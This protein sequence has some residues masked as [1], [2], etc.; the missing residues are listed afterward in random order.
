MSSAGGGSIAYVDAGGA[1]RVGPESAGASPGPAC[2]GVGTR[3]TVTDANVVLGRF[4]GGGL[5]GGGMKLD[6]RR[7]AGVIDE[8]AA[9]LSEFTPRRVTREEAA[10]GVVR[11]ANANMEGALRLVSVERGHDPRGF[12]LVSFGGAG[13][14]HAVALAEALRIPRVLIPPYPGAFSALGVLLA[15]VIKDYSQT[16]MLTLPA[17]PDDATRRRVERQLAAQ[18]TKLTREAV[19]DLRGEG[20]TRER[21]RLQSSLALRYLGQSFELEIPFDPAAPQGVA[22]ALAAFHRAHE[23][24]YGHADAGRAVEVV[25]VRL[26]GVGVTDKPPLKRAASLTRQ[27]PQPE[28]RAVAWLG[29]RKQE[30][31]VYARESLLPGMR[32]DGPGLITEYGSTTLVPARWAAAVDG[33]GSLI[34]EGR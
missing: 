22:R 29:K 3:A 16:V 14:L 10:L 25:S 5:L 12:T 15:D 30:V 21:V 18:F 33:W 13:G 1:L 9:R 4:G 31:S 24:R 8:L 23:A 28:R 20:F 11:V 2:Y 26:K 17:V 7:A 27:R 6:E 32:L 34:I 19:R